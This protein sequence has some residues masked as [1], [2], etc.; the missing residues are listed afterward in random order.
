MLPGDTPS[1]L[2][3]RPRCMI[4]KANMTL[5]DE[6]HHERFVA[7]LTLHLRNGLSQHRLTT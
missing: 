7:S 6:Q 4:R 5:T 1:E 3:Q 2:D